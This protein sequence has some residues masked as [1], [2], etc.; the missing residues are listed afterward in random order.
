MHNVTIN[1]TLKY[2][3]II[4]TTCHILINFE[5]IKF[6]HHPCDA[7]EGKSIRVVI[8]Q[9][10][11]KENFIVFHFSIIIRY[12]KNIIFIMF[13]YLKF[14]SYMYVSRVCVC[15][16]CTNEINW[17]IMLLLQRHFKSVI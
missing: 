7:W 12:E 1:F 11:N 9:K 15:T 5:I 2:S 10:N 4:I 3:I 6:S 14:R 17:K 13:E 16:N 8:N